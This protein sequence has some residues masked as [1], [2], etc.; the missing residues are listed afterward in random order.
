MQSTKD[1]DHLICHEFSNL[2]ELCILYLENL[3]DQFLNWA[4]LEIAH[5]LYSIKASFLAPSGDIKV[6]FFFMFS[7]VRVCGTW[8]Q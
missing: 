6:S 8:D 4:V 1:R 7:W 5:L 3:W 2:T